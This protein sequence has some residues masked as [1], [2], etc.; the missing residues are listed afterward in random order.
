DNS[1]LLGLVR[2]LEHGAPCTAMIRGRRGQLSNHLLR[3]ATSTYRDCPRQCKAH[4]RLKA[5]CAPALQTFAKSSAQLQRCRIDKVVI[6]VSTSPS[7]R[8]T[9]A[10][11]GPS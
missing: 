9:A 11:P 1:S 10:S 2:L 7:M 5:I 8:F 3:T 6:N 4:R